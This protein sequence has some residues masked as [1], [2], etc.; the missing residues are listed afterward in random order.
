MLGGESPDVFPSRT[1]QRRPSVS[2]SASPQ[3]SMPQGRPLRRTGNASAD[4]DDSDSTASGYSNDSGSTVASASWNPVRAFLSSS[5]DNDVD[6]KDSDSTA[7]L[8]SNESGSTVASGSW[9]PVAAFLSASF[10]MLDIDDHNR[11][12]PPADMDDSGSTASLRSNGSGSTVASESWNPVAALK[13][14]G[15]DG[16]ERSSELSEAIQNMSGVEV[17]ALY[18]L[19]QFV[20]GDAQEGIAVFDAA[21]SGAKPF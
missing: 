18:P 20:A 8:H 11:T 7:S 15:I 3:S 12:A 1:P 5:F 21:Y 9:N 14:T 13:G 16:S 6:M 17:R 2:P 10:D 19:E 4:A